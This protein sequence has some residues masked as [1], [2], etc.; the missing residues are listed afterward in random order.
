MDKI[1]VPTDFSNNS[2]P[3]IRFAI[4]M[5][6]R[7]K[8]SLVFIHVENLKGDLEKSK[9]K[10]ESFVQ[11]IYQSMRLEPVDVSFE[12]LKGFMADISILEYCAQHPDIDYICI[13]TRG[14]SF[15]NKILGT[16]TSNLIEKSTVPV[17]AIPNNYRV[18]PLNNLLY[19]TDLVNLEA[20]LQVVVDYARPKGLSIE[21]LHFTSPSTFNL[22]EKLNESLEVKMNYPLKIRIIKNDNSHSL[23]K[24][25]QHQIDKIKPSMVCLF[26]NNNRSFFEKIFLSSLTEDVSYQTNV[27]ILAY[28]KLKSL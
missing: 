12:V 18:K 11:T 27:P 24:N 6:A 25:L 23:L 21:I 20:E 2:K 1:L 9:G 5:A 8:A 3:G 16:N 19:A 4:R 26:T 14:A 28:K 7:N 22:Q 10:L 17:I 15:Y 13:S